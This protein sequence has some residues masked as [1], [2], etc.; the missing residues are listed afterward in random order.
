MVKP[1]GLTFGL[2][3]SAL[4]QAQLLGKPE[5]KFDWGKFAWIETDQPNAISVLADRIQAIR[6]WT[7]SRT[8][9]SRL[10][11]PTAQ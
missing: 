3:A 4:Y 5:V 7:T 8:P 9:R 6:L 2:I 1:D 11:A 10:S